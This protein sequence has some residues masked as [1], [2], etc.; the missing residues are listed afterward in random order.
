MDVDAGLDGLAQSQHHPNAAKG[1]FTDPP[2]NN[3]NNDK[4]AARPEPERSRSLWEEIIETVRLSETG[5]GGYGALAAAVRRVGAMAT[6]H[7]G[8]ETGGITKDELRKTVREELESIL[9]RTTSQAKTWAAIAASPT[10]RLTGHPPEP[11]KTV[12]ARQLREI[13]VRTMN[14]PE[15]LRK[16]TAKEVVAAVNAASSQKGAIAA[17]Q[18]PSGDTIVTFREE[19]AKGW[20]TENTA[21]VKTAFGPTSEIQHRA[22]VVIAKRVRADDL[23]KANLTEV[24]KEIARANGVSVTKVQPKIPKA[25]GPRYASMIVETTS[26]D[27]ANRLCD[28]GLVWDAQIYQCEPFSG[29]LRPLQCYK[30]WGFGHMARWCRGTARCGR[31]SASTH[32][33]GEEA[34]PSNTGEVPKRCPACNGSHTVWDKSCPEANKRWTAAREAYA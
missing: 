31:C 18:L 4:D 3:N 11:T 5:E 34:C 16:R 13:I 26:V 1:G 17:R 6:R 12:P 29:D 10:T 14:P 33:G 24:A 22:Y 9:P 19:E 32:K 21:W 15:D 27:Q 28:R 20:H 30:C 25:E 8:R 23:R 2:A 7:R